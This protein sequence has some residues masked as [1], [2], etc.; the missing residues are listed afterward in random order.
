[1]ERKHKATIEKVLWKDVREQVNA[2]NPCLVK[3]IDALSPNK[4]FP[5]FIVSYPFGESIA[6]QGK[7]YL[8]T[9]MGTVAPLQSSFVSEEVK[10]SLR[11]RNIPTMLVL[12]NSAEIFYEMPDRIIPAHLALP[13]TFV[14]LWEQ[15]DTPASVMTKWGWSL[16]SG[17]RTIYLLPKITNVHGHKKLRKKYGITTHPPKSYLEQWKTFQEIA[18]SKIFPERWECQ[19]LLFT[20]N[21]IKYLE[22]DKA[23]K[24]LYNFLLSYLWKDSTYCRNRNRFDLLWEKFGHAVLETN[25]KPNL[26]L[27]Y[28]VKQLVITG[29]GGLPGLS[30]ATDN[31]SAPID[32]LQKIYI[33]DYGLKH[34]TPVFMTSHSFSFQ[35]NDPAYFSIQYPNLFETVPLPQNMPSTLSAIPDIR[36]LLKTF[37]ERIADDASITDTKIEHFFN[38][39]QLDYFHNREEKTNS[40]WSTEKLIQA[41]KRLRPLPVYK[42]NT[43]FPEASSIING[44]VRFTN[45][46]E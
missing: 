8:P 38:H 45:K 27:T 28:L 35:D 26:Y 31:L 29:V 37:Q 42:K 39:V 43:L 30:V 19:L 32:L 41:D 17:A 15:F 11:N 16:V 21:W 13:G 24:D 10:A 25:I 12:K 46:Y 33:E 4:R 44:C 7:F 3:I 1:M 40:I 18:N 5:F 9:E 22:T 14:G 34:Y 20:D 6:Y 36:F 2:V 23:W